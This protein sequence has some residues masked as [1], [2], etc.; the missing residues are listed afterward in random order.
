MEIK[1]DYND[2]K[3]KSF[4]NEI[5]NYDKFSEKIKN[6]F[7][8]EMDNIFENILTTHETDFL[9][10]IQ[11]GVKIQITD[12]YSQNILND[13][14][15]Q[16]IFNQNLDYIKSYYIDI[17]NIIKNAKK[18]YE[19]QIH[20]NNN[21]EEYYLNRYRKHCCESPIYAH[22]SCERKKPNK[23]L[24]ITENI[25]EFNK[26]DEILFLYCN[27]CNKVYKS[28]FFLSFCIICNTSYYSS[29][30]KKDEN[31]NLLPATWANYHCEQIINEKMKCI[32]CKK[33]LYLN[34]ETHMLECLNKN[35]GFES[36]PS[37]ILWT[38]INCK[39]DFK[40]EA[41][42]FNP[43]ELELI[44]NIIKQTLL[45]KHK[46]HPNR[47]PCCKIN[48]FFTP[49]Y[50]KKECPGILYVGEINNKII[51]VCE[52]CRAI[53]FYDRFIWTC[54]KCGTRFR[55]KKRT[56]R[57]EPL[58]LKFDSKNKN[59][60]KEQYNSLKDSQEYDL[61][62]PKNEEEKSKSHK[63]N[64]RKFNDIKNDKDEIVQKNTD[65]SQKEINNNISYDSLSFKKNN[66]LNNKFLKQYSTEYDTK[67]KKNYSRFLSTKSPD[68][69]ISKNLIKIKD[70]DD[71]EDEKKE[72]MINEKREKEKKDRE[73]RQNLERKEREKREKEKREKEKKEREEKEKKE[74]KER[75]EKERIERERK[76]RER[77]EKEKREREEKERIERE[78]KEKEKREREEKEKKEKE[79]K[80]KRE[81]ERE[82]KKRKEKEEN[83]RREREEK[84]KKERERKKLEEQKKKEK[85]EQEKKLE[86]KKNYKSPEKNDNKKVIENRNILQNNNK[87]ENNKNNN[88]LKNSKDKNNE[89][90]NI[91]N[92][93]VDIIEESEEED[94][95]NELN[96]GIINFGSGLQADKIKEEI[97][98]I[99]AQG[100]IPQFDVEDYTLFKQLGEG[101]YG[102]I[103]SVYNNKNHSKK[104]AMKK[105]IAHDLDELDGFHQEFE[106]VASCSH[107]NIMKIFGVCVRF[108]DVTTFALYVLMEMAIND[109]DKEIKEHLKIHKLYKEEELIYILRQ[110]TSALKFMQVNKKIAHR[111][112]KPQNI[113]I[114]ENDE[115]KINDY[116]I[117]DFGEAKE[118]KISKQLNTLRGTELYMSPALY[119]GLKDDLDDVTHDPY[120]SD[121]FSL[122]FCFI[123]AACLNFNII[124]ELRDVK[125][126]NKIEKILHKHLKN[127]YTEKFIKVLLV[128]L[129]IEENK[130]VDFEGLEKYLVEHFPEDE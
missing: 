65:N 5:K 102:V 55:D 62:S 80:E 93:K 35:C 83:E 70:N 92:P 77:K 85:K 124:Y 82:E 118:V 130:R 121:V 63:V 116:K 53:N 96:N 13:K 60:E 69:K 32:K 109:W 12:L 56:V 71:I 97:K 43:L 113:L 72:K 36:K 91:K 6:I 37:R 66:L 59:T 38:C 11:N 9:S 126:M 107:P 81:R 29:I 2:E 78:R 41:I 94:E 50:H 25:E 88:L 67:D 105:I 98:N 49:F 7:L 75:E 22:H 87:I 19:S 15:Y 16:K 42:V 64:L 128:M 23:F 103:Y 86:I 111:D 30:L 95:L 1:K 44:K 40:S 34:L 123:Y 100:D 21:L 46:A 73:I 122:G 117:A 84:E 8:V 17:Y 28:K 18:F 129:E 48:T 27:I 127:K 104:F 110:L 115:K 47:M 99:L 57:K 51:I 10:S 61:S 79:E 33:Y 120:K 89:N 58:L 26:N 76:E 20:N 106:F 45:I 119:N 125:E 90:L 3:Y 114:F 54:P 52:K 39:T 14:N 68:I 24:I 4:Q 108:L 74:R 101:S 112:I 31:P